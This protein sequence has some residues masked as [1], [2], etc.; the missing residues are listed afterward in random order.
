MGGKRDLTWIFQS[1]L[2][3]LKTNQ[4]VTVEVQLAS[5]GLPKHFIN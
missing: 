5:G 1:S 2:E 3:Q 4:I